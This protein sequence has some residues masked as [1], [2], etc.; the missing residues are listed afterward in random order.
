VLSSNSRRHKKSFE[1]KS[2]CAAV[3]LAR[4]EKAIKKAEK[5]RT[6]KNTLKKKKLTSD[7]VSFNETSELGTK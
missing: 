6:S 5:A 7:M 2:V 1:M 3:S 4:Q